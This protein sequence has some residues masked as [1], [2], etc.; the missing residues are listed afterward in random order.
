L[1]SRDAHP[2]SETRGGLGRR[3]V[4]LVAFDLD[5]TLLSSDLSLSEQVLRSAGRLMSEGVKIVIVT[6]RMHRTAE[7]FARQL[8]LVGQPLVSFNGAMVRPVGQGDTWWHVPLET[9]PAL[10]VLAFLAGRGL[11]PLVFD[12]DRVMAHAPDAVTE[13]YSRIAGI[14]PE[15]VGDL[16]AWITADGPSPARPTKILQAQSPDLM[17]DLREAAE[18]RFSRTLNVVTSYPFFLEFMNGTV[19]KGRALAE[20]CRRLGIL[21]AD[22]AA[23]GDGLNDLDMIT[24]AGLG[25]AM[26]Y[27]PEELLRAADAIAAGPP[28]EGVA[29]FIEDNL[30]GAGRETS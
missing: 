19:S 8:G 22:V 1:S 21:A 16:Q 30:C 5:G 25:V 18:A 17:P 28:G 27:G 2:P 9:S 23:F 12:G 7:K 11:R 14:Q 29:R 24:W 26:E 6:G 3:A 20:V 13:Q 15:Y 4:R 10:E